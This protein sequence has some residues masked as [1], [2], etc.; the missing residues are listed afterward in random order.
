MDGRPRTRRPLQ[1]LPLFAILALFLGLCLSSCFV[2]RIFKQH[3]PSARSTVRS[4][5]V[6]RTA[7]AAA[8][9][10]TPPRLAFDARLVEAQAKA[11]ISK[12]RYERAI[13]AYRDALK[14]HP[15]DQALSAGYE[16]GLLE[17]GRAAGAAFARKEF[18][19]AGMLYT[20]VTE[21]NDGAPA[22]MAFLRL[23]ADRCARALTEEGLALYRQGRLKEAIACWREVLE[24]EP[25]DS[26]VRAAVETASLQIKKLSKQN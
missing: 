23:Q 5:P 26:K 13:R 8:P 19:R 11:D 1:R 17:A 24:F 12:G 2:S 25:S 7:P 22:K 20:L 4:R 15:G 9:Q 14:L 10:G 6:A 16:S 21:G 3:G 18:A